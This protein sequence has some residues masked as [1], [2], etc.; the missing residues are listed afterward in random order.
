MVTVNDDPGVTVYAFLV[1]V[2]PL[3]PP[4]VNRFPPPLGVAMLPPD[5]PPPTQK[6]SMEVTPAG[7]VN[8]PDDVNVLEPAAALVVAFTLL[9]VPLPFWISLSHFIRKTIK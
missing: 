1:A 2:L 5:A 4:P 7:T 8:V 6:M 3:P 9:A